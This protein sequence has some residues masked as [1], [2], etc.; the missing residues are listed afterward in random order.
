MHMY[1][2]DHHTETVMLQAILHDKADFIMQQAVEGSLH[3][4]INHPPGKE[5]ALRKIADSDIG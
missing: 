3:R 1:G 2:Y 4:G 5:D